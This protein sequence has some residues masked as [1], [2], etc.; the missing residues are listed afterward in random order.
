MVV[1][2]VVGIVIFSPICSLVICL[3]AFQKF[4][5]STVIIIIIIY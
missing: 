2:V 4:Y 3:Y 5:D 1:E